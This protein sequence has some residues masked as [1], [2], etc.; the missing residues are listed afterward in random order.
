MQ[1]QKQNVM[2]CLCC[3]LSLRHLLLADIVVE[4]YVPMLKFRCKLLIVVIPDKI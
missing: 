3:D 1:L 4:F 2:T